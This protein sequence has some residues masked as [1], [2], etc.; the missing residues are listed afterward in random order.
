MN[1]SAK[2]SYRIAKHL[3]GHTA[4]SQTEISRITG[5]SIGLVNRVVHNL[6]E[7]EI[8]AAEYGRCVLKD[9]VKLLEKIGFDRSFKKLE[10]DAFRL[11]TVSV[12]ESEEYLAGTF[13]DLDVGY[14]FTVFS[15]LRHY[16]EYHISYPLIHVYV[17]DVAAVNDI[18]RGEGPIPIVALRPDRSDVLWE[19][20]KSQGMYI[21]DRIQVAIDLFSSGIGRDAAVKLLEAH[22]DGDAA[23]PR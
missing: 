17:S 1:L 9:R 23:G 12:D 4:T 20:R 6:A 11:T 18:E 15:G 19:A 21:C 14:G 10:V 7:Y 16:F 13:E 8:V 5:A 22:R 3:L 2:Q